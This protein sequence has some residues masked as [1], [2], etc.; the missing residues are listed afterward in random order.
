MLFRSLAAVSK[1]PTEDARRG[2][3]DVH[4]VAPFAA[5]SENAAASAPPAAFGI[6]NDAVASIMSLRR[7]FLTTYPDAGSMIDPYVVLAS[8]SDFLSYVP[9]A[10]Q[11]GI[12]APFPSMWFG[13]GVSPGAGIMRAM[14]GVEMA[15]SY[16]LLLG[17]PLAIPLI[18]G[19][20]IGAGF[21]ALTI[22]AIVVCLIVLAIP[23][24]GT[25]HRMRYGYFMLVVGLGAAGWIMA[26][27]LI[28]ERFRT[29]RI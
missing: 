25:L 7:G 11:I 20:A 3:P 13:I 27:R 5:R 15:L 9:R 28:L 21:L 16:I 6:L 23:I 26:I 22:C 29:V 24:V 12:L 17:I 19:R 18:S 4:T 10:L 1:I 2:M 8:P 14:T